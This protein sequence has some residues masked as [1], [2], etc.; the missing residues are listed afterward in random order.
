MAHE[1]GKGDKRRPEDVNLYNEGYD[2]IFGKK[3]V[4][5]RLDDVAVLQQNVVGMQQLEQE[6]ISGKNTTK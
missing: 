6:R 1:A 3:P 5:G 2:R 4:K